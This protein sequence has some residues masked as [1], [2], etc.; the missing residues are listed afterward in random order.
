MALQNGALVLNNAEV[1]SRSRNKHIISLGFIAKLTDLESR[2]RSNCSVIYVYR[3][4]GIFYT[5]LQ[6]ERV[7][8]VDDAHTMEV[9]ERLRAGK[10]NWHC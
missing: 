7:F 1:K 6:I 9:E 4:L 2:L 10:G 8:V 5:V 3:K